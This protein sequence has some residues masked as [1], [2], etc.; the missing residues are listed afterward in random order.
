MTLKEA[1]TQRILDICKQKDISVNKMADICGITQSTLNNI[2]NTGSE[3]PQI[4]TIKKICDGMEMRLEDFF[5]D[6]VFRTLEQEI[7]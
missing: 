5:A 4:S 1:I 7:K 3:N 2:V 6:E